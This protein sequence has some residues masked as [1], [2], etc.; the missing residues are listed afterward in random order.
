MR[1]ALSS[2]QRTLRARM[3]AYARHQLSPEQRAEEKTCRLL[4]TQLAFHEARASTIRDRL[5][6]LRPT[7]AAPDA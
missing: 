4:E 6:D 2:E 3:A 7:Q 1:I 5:A